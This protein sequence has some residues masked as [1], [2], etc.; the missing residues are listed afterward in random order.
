MGTKHSI[1]VIDNDCTSNQSICQLLHDNN[2]TVCS[3]TSGTEGQSMIT[4]I[5][6]DMIILNSDLY[7]A[8]ANEIVYSTRKWSAI[9]IIII[10]ENENISN[11][12]SL[13]DAGVDDYI[14]KP[15]HEKEFLARIRAAFRHYHFPH[16]ENKYVHEN[17]T[18]SFDKRIV[19]VN[20]TI[21]HLTNIEYKILSY[22][23]KHNGALVTYP[24]LMT[25]VWGPYI[26]NN[27]RI[28]RVN[29]ANIRKKI[30]SDS[31]N[32]VHIITEPGIGYRMIEY[33][34]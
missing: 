32:P 20:E 11:T 13:L 10:S 14:I 1:L 9:P 8:D 5:C 25:H 4:S 34:G 2:Y 16:N 22:I 31:S 21:L 29:I 17:L 3:T 28:L 26:D 27:N 6:P 24:D 7:D 18:I 19:I 30:E 15:F 23:A 33:K 12:V